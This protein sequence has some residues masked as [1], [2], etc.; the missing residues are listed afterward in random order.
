ML[1]ILLALLGAVTNAAYFII[2]KNYITSLDP[3]I[4][5][6]IG[7]TLGGI[8]LFVVS[9]RIGFPVIG[10][11]F[12]PAV[13]ITVILNICGLS[14]IFRALSSSDLSLSMPMLSF[15]P[16]ILIGTSYVI[17]HEVPSFFGFIGICII[18]SGSYVLNISA[19]HEH[20]LDPVRSMIRNRGSW[21]MLIVAF[22]FAVS[23]SFDKIAMLNSDPFFGMALTVL[24]IGSAFLIISAYSHTVKMRRDAHLTHHIPE[25]KE[26][27][28]LQATP[29]PL[30]QIAGLSFLIGLFVAIEAASINVAYTLQ[31]VPY[32]IA[33]KRLSIIFMV[34]YGTIVLSEGDLEKRVMGATIMVAGA[35]I[36]LLF[37]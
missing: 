32:V 37:A 5:T 29:I 36:I 34:L 28:D 15:T 20:F 30:Q 9:A 3:R 35:I 11:E 18:V 22:L 23:I 25:A 17:L 27:K 26:Q 10:P 12:F 31:I 2:I 8:L 4:L 33:I 13:A 7:F 1:W 19:G 21:Y 14:L 24:A 16:V 6:G